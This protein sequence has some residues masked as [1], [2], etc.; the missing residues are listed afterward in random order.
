M[1][2]IEILLKVL[3]LITASAAVIGLVV[4]L[5]TKVVKKYKQIMNYETDIEVL[6]KK[7]DDLSKALNSK[8]DDLST[9]TLAHFQT[10]AAENQLH[11]SIFDAVLDGLEQLGCNHSVPEA[12]GK[13]YDYLNEEGHKVEKL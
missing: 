8:V 13:I 7:V 5:V 6:N 9:S 3:G 11:M 4:K 12:R 2:I 10:L 1:G